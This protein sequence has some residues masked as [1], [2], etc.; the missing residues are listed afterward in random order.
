MKSPRYWL[1]TVLLLVA[2][3]AMALDYRSVTEPAVLYDAPSLKGKPL[4]VI[5]R[6]TPVEVVV[7][8]EGW[9]KVRDASGGLA[10]IE[11]RLLGERRTVQVTAARA[12]VRTAASAE[13]PLAFEA[14]RDVVL[15]LT[16]PLPVNGWA[17]V[18]HRDGQS[19]FVR[20]EQVWG[21]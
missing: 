3:P 15:E 17:R 1:A 16:D 6:Q 20:A 14:E 11:K 7:A 8:L 10:W 2:M 12:Q 18:R 5:A 19:G 13:A 4:F 21:L 9:S